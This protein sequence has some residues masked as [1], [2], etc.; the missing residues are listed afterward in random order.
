MLISPLARKICIQKGIDPAKLCGSGPRGRIMAADVATPG[1]IPGQKGRTVVRDFAMAPTRPEKDGY[2][3]YDNAVN[4]GA[5]ARVSLPIA[6]QCE[7]LL[8]RRYSLFDFIVR[9]VV[10]ACLSQPSWLPDGEKVNLLLFADAGRQVVALPDAAGKSVYRLNR[11][12]AK[13]AGATVPQ[14]Y[15]PHITVCDT[16]I[17]RQQVADYLGSDVRPL[18]GFATRGELPKAELRVGGDNW[19]NEDL[20]YTF[21]V[22]TAIPAAEANRM[23]ARL[24]DLLYNPVNLLMQH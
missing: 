11:D 6:V 7:K 18:F 12:A 10:R 5:L 22:S 15:Y 9:A 17:T 14:G 23:A 20:P 8:E 1:L 2:Y 3:V 21:Y 4:M 24:G 16:D 13:A 19:R